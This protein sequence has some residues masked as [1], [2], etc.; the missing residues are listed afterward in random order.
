MS[1]Y[2]QDDQ[3]GKKQSKIGSGSPTLGAFFVLERH[4]PVLL[5]IDMAREIASLIFE[6]GSENKAVMAFAHRLQLASGGD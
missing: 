6:H 4:I 5:D 2:N 1:D 3:S